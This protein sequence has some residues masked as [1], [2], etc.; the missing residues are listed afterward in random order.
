MLTNRSFRAQLVGL[1]GKH[2]LLNAPS[3][4]GRS[5]GDAGIA[6]GPRTL[7]TTACRRQVVSSLTVDQCS[8]PARV[9]GCSSEQLCPHCL[10]PHLVVPESRMDASLIAD[11]SLLTVG[12]LAR[13][14]QLSLGTGNPQLDL[15]EIW[16]NVDYQVRGFHRLPPPSI[17]H[18]RLPSPSTAFHCPPP[19]TR[20]SSGV[21][22]RWPSRKSLLPSAALQL[23]LRVFARLPLAE[24]PAPIG[25]RWQ[26]LG[27]AAPLRA[28]TQPAAL[29]TVFDFRRKSILT[30]GVYDAPG[31]KASLDF[32]FPLSTAGSRH[33]GAVRASLRAQ[34]RN[35]GALEARRPAPLTTVVI[36]ETDVPKGAE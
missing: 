8:S 23:P 21:N 36:E 35:E 24:L 17:A 5:V 33:E 13:L 34:E 7:P 27:R 29:L 20:A 22:A 1:A 14:L 6:A 30:I 4:V 3:A 26:D 25:G 19:Q 15:Q 11:C 9:K 31:E 18:R 32:H 10:Q 12:D 16:I 2:G 28:S